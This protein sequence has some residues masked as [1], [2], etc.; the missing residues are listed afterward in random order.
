MYS[1]WTIALVW[2]DPKVLAPVRDREAIGRFLPAWRNNSKIF[3]S[4]PARAA[5]A[6]PAGRFPASGNSAWRSV[7]APFPRFIESTLGRL[8]ACRRFLPGRR[9]KAFCIPPAAVLPGKTRSRQTRTWPRE[10]ASPSSLASQFSLPFF[11]RGATRR[12]FVV[13]A[14]R[15]PGRSI[16]PRVLIHAFPKG[17]CR[18][19]EQSSRFFFPSIPRISRAFSG[20]ESYR[21]FSTESFLPSEPWY[22]H[23]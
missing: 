3:D 17:N 13:C 16:F 7:V 19:T 2:C 10:V 11:F 14:P 12:F 21:K 15:A 20:A 1:F 8:G 9:A 18:F 6:G 5:P 23:I 22:I 4:A